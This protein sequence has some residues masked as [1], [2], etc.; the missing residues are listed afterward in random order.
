MPARGYVNE[1]E[2][3]AV[4]FLRA[5]EITVL[6]RNDRRFGA[7]MDIVGRPKGEGEL[8]IFEVKQWQ[9]N[10]AFPAVSAAQRKRLAAAIGSLEG[11][12]G[13]RLPVVLYALLVNTT[14]QSICLVP[15]ADYSGTC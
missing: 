4:R 15:L 8:C 10:A 2:D 3:I 5:S 12:A 13:S 9:K 11:E 6:S 7:E 1:A 14:R